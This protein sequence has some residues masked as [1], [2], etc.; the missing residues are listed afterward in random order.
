MAGRKLFGR[1]R[2]GEESGPKWR[3]LE[4]WRKCSGYAIPIGAEADEP[5]SGPKRKTRKTTTTC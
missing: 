4:W 3:A 1:T 2:H 5:P